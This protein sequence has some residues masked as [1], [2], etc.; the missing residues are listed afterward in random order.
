VDTGD[1]AAL[2]AQIG[3]WNAYMHRR[4][5]LSSADTDELEDHLRSRIAELVDAGLQPDEA[6][7]VAVK[8]MGS[9][10]ALTREF[11]R[12]HSDRLWKQLV[13]T[14]GT[15]E[16]H[17]GS[18]ARRDLAVMIG[19]AVLAAVAIKVPAMFGLSLEHDDGFYSRNFSLFCLV[20]L[21]GYFAWVRR[22]SPAVVGVLAT[23]FALA[24]AAANAYPFDDDA[25]ASVLT[26][27]HL[28]I[29]LWLTVGL[30]YLAGDWR[31]APRRMDFIRFTGEW[32]I[33]YVLI[34]LGGGVLTAV[35]LGTFD[36]IGVDAETFIGSWLLPCGAMGAVV[37]SAWLVEAK[38]SVI[39]N[40]APVLSRVFTPLFV[41]ALLAFLGGVVGTRTWLGDDRDVLIVFDLM[42]AVVLGLLLYG[43][44]AREP[45]ARP[46][47]FDRL[48]LALVVAALL[49]DILVLAA[50]IG[51][52]SEFGFSANKTAALGENV[53]LLA[54]LAWS[55]W[56]LLGF[57]RGRGP[58]A[59]LARWQ[60]SYLVV[61][62]AWAWAVV[63][64]F[65]VIFGN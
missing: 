52:I 23:L 21:A 45:A 4:R 30:A 60:T 27:I 62:A 7:L 49:I 32:F 53:I 8:R 25:P 59:L 48:Q 34:A 10:D 9:L 19:F 63:L 28:P 2:E 6:F 43:I 1:D 65:P 36:A 61:Y 44:S 56:L 11:A 37:V 5:E 41:A 22:V 18:T 57:L 24:V 55:A 29:A 17:G 14:G 16:G 50:V 31:S 20:P 46:G 64:A 3:E 40:M 38:Q 54:N 47:W 35:T 12:E 42:L 39:E 33:Y 26:A 51:R 13:L 15:D 58:F